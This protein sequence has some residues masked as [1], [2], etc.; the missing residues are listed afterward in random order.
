VASRKR[1]LPAGTPLGAAVAA[2][3]L[4]VGLFISLSRS[5]QWSA[6]AAL[7]VAPKADNVGGDTLASLY[8]TLSRGQITSTYAEIFRNSEVKSAA[9]ERA[10]VPRAKRPGVVV[11]VAAVADTSV[12]NV[13]ATARSPGVATRVADGMAAEAKNRADAMTT[14]YGV[15]VA[16]TAAGSTTREGLGTATLLALSIFVALVAGLLTQQGWSA[17]QRSRRLG[18]ELTDDWPKLAPRAQSTTR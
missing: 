1:W 2:L 16:S 10:T 18:R 13:S 17:V 9:E 8:D 7:L 12:I 11:T 5:A 6:T 15:S 14:P 3:L 4:A